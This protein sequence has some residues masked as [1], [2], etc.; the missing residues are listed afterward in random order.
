MDVFLNALADRDN[1]KSIYQRFVQGLPVAVY[2]TDENGL[3]TMYNEAAAQLWGRRPALG[4]EA[5]CGSYRIFLADG[6]ELL[7]SQCPMAVL[8]TTKQPV[9]PQEIII[10]RPDGSRRHVLA[11]PQLL[12]DAGGRSIGAFNVLVDI[13]ENRQAESA[14]AHL[15]AIVASSDD[16][17]ISKDLTS[18]ITSWN[19]GAQQLFGY[20]AEEMIGQS[21]MRLIPPD[22]QYEEGILLDRIRRGERVHHYETVRRRKDGGLID[23]SITVSPV[24]DGSGRIIGASK[25]ARDITHEK[26]KRDQQHQ[27]YEF[28][29]HVNRAESLQVLYERA[30]EAILRSLK[31]DRAAIL[32]FDAEGTMRFKAWRGLSDGYRQA[33][34]GHSPWKPDDPAPGPILVRDVLEWQIAGRLKDLVRNEGIGSL[35]FFP[36]T[37]GGRLLGKFMVY[38]DRPYSMS[39]DGIA[40]AQAIAQTLALGIERKAAEDC[41]RERES[42]LRLALE[43][44]RM[45]SWEWDIAT[46]QVMWSDTLEAIHG[47]AP[48]TFDGTFESYQ[49]DIHPEDRDRVLRSIAQTLECDEPYQIEYRIVRPDG[50]V[51]WVE[52]KGKLYRTP[53]GVPTRMIGVCADITERK[54]AEQALRESEEKLRKLAGQLEQLVVERTARL[55]ALATELNLTEQ[56]ERQQLATELHDHLQQLLVLGKLKLG[57]GKRLAESLPACVEVMKQTDDVLSQA[58]TYTRTL[59]ADLSPPVLKEFGL[60]AALVWL[61]EQMRQHHLT[62]LLRTLSEEPKVSEEHAVLLFQSV[63]ELLINSAKYAGT[64]VATVSVRREGNALCVEVRDEGKGF[65]TTGA[66]QQEG[67]ALSSRFGLF[68]IRERMKALGGMFE[69]QSAPEKGTTATLR[70]PLTPSDGGEPDSGQAG[71]REVGEVTSVAPEPQRQ[72]EAAI[73]VLLVDD[74][75]MMRQG[76]R[77]VLEAYADVHIVGEAGD[78]EEAIASVHQH[79]PSVVVMDINMPRLNGIDATAR[80]KSAYP[81]LKVIGLSVNADEPNQKAMRQAGAAL[82]LTKEAAVDDLYRA[83][84]QALAEKAP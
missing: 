62:V 12:V 84:R 82:L 60:T 40:L 41:L 43:A 56:R 70:L 53:A 59:V 36:L 46:G 68:S 65:D 21:I 15:A 66:W 3:I 61:A 67:A 19:D 39:A 58:L 28:A 72:G 29:T 80:L 81:D 20:R 63:R 16:A 42:Q 79:R 48:G 7:L 34:E 44:G 51:N 2:C 71:S 55:R 50:A 47:L 25:I 5:W 17:I 52:G 14:K 11:H 45:G 23:I 9:P 37:Y 31:T 27:L 18:V 73:R 22:R 35:A 10:E 64:G 32:L 30:L 78:G 54:Q 83:I 33:V 77:S 26:T 6:T 13:S 57:Q 76:L 74:H 4:S 75:A 24:R 8:V 1:A 69:L 38:F 49:Q